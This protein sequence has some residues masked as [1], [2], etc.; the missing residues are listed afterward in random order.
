MSPDARG[1]VSCR[2][3]GALSFLLGW[4]AGAAAVSPCVDYA[5][6]LHVTGWLEEEARFPQT[7]SGRFYS[8]SYVGVESE[9][10]RHVLNR[11]HRFPSE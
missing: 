1:A 5:S 2:L 7:D 10:A 9:L 3:A 4:T 8:L 11:R 6:H